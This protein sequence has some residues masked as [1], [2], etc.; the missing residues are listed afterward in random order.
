MYERAEIGARFYFLEGADVIYL[1]HADV[2]DTRALA[3]LRAASLTE[4]GFL[5]PDRADAAFV[6]R[7]AGA[8]S[9]LFREH[10]I[11]AWVTCDDECV[12]GSAFAVLYD[13]LPYPEGSLHAEVSGV[14]VGSAYRGRG[15][16]AEM[17]REIVSA[18]TADGARKIFLRPSVGSRGLY[19]RIGFIDAGEIMAFA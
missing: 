4:M 10:R 12:V 5:P 13:R 16:A 17:V 7:A 6:A 9:R 1:R 19:E 8:I 15:F 3:E 18:V 11:V 2:L 14:Y